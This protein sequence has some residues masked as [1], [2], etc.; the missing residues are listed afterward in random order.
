MIDLDNKQYDGDALE[1][2]NG[3]CTDFNYFMPPNPQVPK[4]TSVETSAAYQRLSHWEIRHFPSE[5]LH[6][7]GLFDHDDDNC[8]YNCDDCESQPPFHWACIW[9]EW[10]FFISE[11]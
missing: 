2:E 5:I 1:S 8:D 6:L 11:S 3:G 4:H 7:S 9:V 10:L